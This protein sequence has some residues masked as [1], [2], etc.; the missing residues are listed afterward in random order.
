MRGANK[1]CRTFKETQQIGRFYLV[2]ASHA[3]GPTFRIFILPDGEKA[4]PNGGSNAPLNDNAVEVYGIVSG[5]PGW[6]ES[7][8]WLHKGKWQNDF[9]ALYEERKKRNETVAEQTTKHKEDKQSEEDLR[10]KG[11]LE[12]YR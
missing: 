12:L 10:I 3:R 7:Y 11:L 6:T 2:V 4:K 8:G 1:F 9:I 5:Q